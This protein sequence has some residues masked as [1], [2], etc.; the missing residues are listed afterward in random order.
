AMKALN[1][2]DDIQSY[3]MALQASY[4]PEENFFKLYALYKNEA[5]NLFRRDAF[6]KE[7]LDEFAQKVPNV[8]DP[9]TVPVGKK[10]F[11]PKGQIRFYPGGARTLD[12]IDDFLA[13]VSPGDEMIEL[14][15]KVREMLLK[16]AK[17][18]AGQ[19][20]ITKRVPAYLIDENI[21]ARLNK[22]TTFFWGDP[23]AALVLRH[24]NKWYMAWKGMATA[25]RLPFHLRNAYSNMFLMYVMDVEPH[26][27]PVRMVQAADVRLAGIGAVEW[28][29]L[30]TA[31]GKS[32]S[33]EQIFRTAKEMQ[34]IK[35]TAWM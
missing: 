23:A 19:V 3:R 35:G 7:V 12:I 30:K 29:A 20:G 8:F 10:L 21:A 2:I 9:G 5:G 15:P 34:V 4:T 22:V 18:S 16:I 32:I 28:P 26:M 31:A 27:I 13:T 11:F 33:A 24:M 14:T 25:M 17:S 6:V 1:N